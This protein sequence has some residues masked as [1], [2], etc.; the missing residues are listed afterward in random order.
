MLFTTETPTATLSAYRPRPFIPKASVTSPEILFLN[1][2]H[3]H[4]LGLLSIRGWKIFKM[5][6]FKIKIA[7]LALNINAISSNA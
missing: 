7:V 2:K 1:L 6:K 4:L 3:L 5:I